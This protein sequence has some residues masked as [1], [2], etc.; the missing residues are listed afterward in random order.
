MSSPINTSQTGELYSR[1]NIDQ[2]KA[3]DNLMLALNEAL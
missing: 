3:K 2:P 1:K